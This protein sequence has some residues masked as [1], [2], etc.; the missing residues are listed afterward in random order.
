MEEPAKRH[1]GIVEMVCI[2]AL[3]A[4]VAVFGY[5]VIRE[6]RA[7]GGGTRAITAPAVLRTDPIRGPANAVVTIIEFSDYECSF[8][9][10]LQPALKVLLAKYSGNIRHVWKDFPITEHHDQALAAAT[11]AR[12]AQEQNAFWEMH[13]VLFTNSQR[14]STGLY[15]QLATDLG[16]DKDAFA[17]CMNSDR[18]RSLIQETF[19]QGQRAGVDGTP[20]LFVNNRAVSTV[21]SQ[22]DLDAIITQALH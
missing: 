3:V 9:R 22:E 21:P 1:N 4:V 7:I 6:R 19:D 14:L 18:I 20:Y 15:A 16:L 13:D 8:C 12:C 2:V 5:R 17:A 11:A 10:S